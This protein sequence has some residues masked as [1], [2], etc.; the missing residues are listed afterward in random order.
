MNHSYGKVFMLIV[1]SLRTDVREPPTAT[2][3]QIFPLLARFCSS[4][5]TGKTLVGC[6]WLDVTNVMASKRSKK[7]KFDFQL[8]SV[9]HKR[10]LHKL[11]NISTVYH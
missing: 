6:L 5:R 1:G 7:E 3:S 4:Q 9:A 10:L 2:G 8:P 11:P